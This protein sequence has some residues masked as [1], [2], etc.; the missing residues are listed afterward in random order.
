MKKPKH[1]TLGAMQARIRRQFEKGQARMDAHARKM[2]RVVDR[3]ILRRLKEMERAIR[4][5]EW[6]L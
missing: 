5:W 2:S 6:T 3:V 4:E 1:E